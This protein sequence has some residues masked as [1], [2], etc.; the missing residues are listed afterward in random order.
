MFAPLIRLFGATL[1]AVTALTAPIRAQA[2]ETS[3]TAAWV[4]DQTTGTILLNKNADM[5]LPPASMSKLMTIYMAFQAVADGRLLP[6]QTLPVSDHA[7][8]FRGSTMFLDT[9]DRVRVEDLLRGV[10]VLSGNDASVVLA[11]ALSPDGTEAGFARLM[12]EKARELGMLNSHFVNASGWPAQGHVMSMHDLGILA[13]H[14]IRDF[15]TFYPLF[16]ETEFDFDNRAP[17][18][19]Q[20]RNPILEMELGPDII[21]DGLKTG[22]TMEAGYGLVGSAKQG[23][24]RIIFVITGLETEQARA[25]ESERIVNWAFRQYALREVGEAGTRIAEADVWMGA[26]PSVGLTIAEDLSI[27]IPSVLGGEIAAEVIY[28]SPV[29]APVEAG[30]VLGELVIARE[31]LPEVRVALV[32]EAAVATGGFLVR[33]Q[34]AL[35]VLFDRVMSSVSEEAA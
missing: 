31:G 8:S 28:T 34:T 29:P 18:N 4:Y 12:T 33:V 32:A 21:A 22:H 30:Q 15:P 17:A 35:S 9:T 14:L 20:N 24:R 13:D 5:P 23:D 2:F 19:T 27:L 16:A 7:V 1:V 6:D 25:E 26:A 3:A 10:I 11:E